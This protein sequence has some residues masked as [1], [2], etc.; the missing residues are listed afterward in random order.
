[1]NGMNH[2]SIEYKRHKVFQNVFVFRLQK[3]K[4]QSSMRTSSHLLHDLRLGP[5]IT[6]L[7]TVSTLPRLLVLSELVD[8]ILDLASQVRTHECS[9]MHNTA[10]TLAIPPQSI[11]LSFWSR[12]LNNHTNRIG[13]SDRVMRCIARQQK[14]FSFIN[15]DV[16]VFARRF[17]GLEQ[18]TTTVLVE[19]LGGA[20]DVVVCSCVGAADNHDGQRVGV[21]AVVVDRGFEEVGVLL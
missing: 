10:T 11:H 4:P 15:V 7:T 8:S 6:D 3:I 21:D 19:E 18:H 1:M 17:D 14:D 2:C 20:V 9:L 13:K 12:L 16:S 5:D